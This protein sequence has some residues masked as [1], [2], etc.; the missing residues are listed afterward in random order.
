MLRVKFRHGLL[1]LLETAVSK[2]GQN[3]TS[4]VMSL[5]HCTKSGR[6]V[7]KRIRGS[8]RQAS[9]KRT[10]RKIPQYKLISR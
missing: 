4:L 9:A 3:M 6:I 8:V 1:C 5:S 7:Y 10:L 2:Q